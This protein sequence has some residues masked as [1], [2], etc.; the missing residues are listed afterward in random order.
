MRSR[1]PVMPA[2]RCRPFQNT[3][4]ADSSRV[5]SLSLAR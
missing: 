2:S 3:A 5:M 1:T 4:S